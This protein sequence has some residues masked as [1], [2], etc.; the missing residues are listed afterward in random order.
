MVNLNTG[1]NFQDFANVIDSVGDT[2]TL[3][4]N[5]KTTSNISGNEKLTEG[6]PI[7]FTAYIVRKNRPWFLDKAG[8][9][10]GG[11]AVMNVKGTQAIKKDDEI[12]WQ[13]V[14]YRV[15]D[16]LDRDQIGGNKAY[17]RVN[18]FKIA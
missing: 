14:P 10:E 5:T 6:T 2:V 12:T 7:T 1:V 9:L 3:T 15:Q 18:L 16:V 13:G 4:P 11:D 8:L 17:K